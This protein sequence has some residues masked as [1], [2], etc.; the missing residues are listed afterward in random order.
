MRTLLTVVVGVSILI[1]VSL[2]GACDNAADEK[3]EK[4]QQAHLLNTAQCVCANKGG[5]QLTMYDLG[6]LRFLCKE[7]VGANPRYASSSMTCFP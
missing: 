1:T 5:V 6:M 3:T 7:D 4:A 2:F